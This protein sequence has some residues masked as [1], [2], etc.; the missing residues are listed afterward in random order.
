MV[1]GNCWE[2]VGICGNMWEFVG[3]DLTE[4]YINGMTSSTWCGRQ[5]GVK[6]DSGASL[7]KKRSSVKTGL[8]L[9]LMDDYG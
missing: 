9:W 7:K 2:L 5:K 3:I 6:G 1:G 4:E 8:G